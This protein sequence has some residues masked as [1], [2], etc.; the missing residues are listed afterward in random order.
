MSDQTY[1]NVAVFDTRPEKSIATESPLS[2]AYNKGSVPA[3]TQQSQVLLEEKPFL[4][5][6]ILRGGAIVLDEAIREVLGINLPGRPLGLVHDGSGERSV[7]WMS[8]DEWLVIVPGGEEFDL[9]NR[10]REKL[11][12]AHFAIL[13]ASGGQTLVELSGEKAREVLMKSVPYDVH[14]ANFP[15]GKGVSI[16]F[17]KSSAILRRPSEERYELVLRRSFAD[18]CYRWLLDAGEE[19]GIG[20]KQSI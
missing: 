4:G 10:L 20:V 11:G 15:V 12:D 13:N 5:H 19:F 1:G 8:P 9:E 18:Y 2:V 3:P 16:V 7:Q 17:A 14:P 6:L